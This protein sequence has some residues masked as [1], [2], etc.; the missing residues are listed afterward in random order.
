VLFFTDSDCQPDSRWIEAGLE[1]ISGLGPHGRVAGEVEIFPKGKDWTGPELYDLVTYLRQEEYSGEGWCATANLITRR[2][3]FDLAGPFDD[4][5]SGTGDSEWGTRANAL[6]S[7]IAYCPAALIRHPARASYAGLK[8]KIRRMAGGHYQEEL[9]GRFPM[10]GLFGHL[11]ILAPDQLK[12]TMAFPGLSERQRMTILWVTMRLNLVW[13][14]EMVRVR[15][16]SGK[17]NRS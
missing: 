16:L 10:R 3:A 7:E 9:R 8:K 17:P 15:H 5:L 2:A 1:A 11:Y 4:E 14:L 13:F 6:G 12:R